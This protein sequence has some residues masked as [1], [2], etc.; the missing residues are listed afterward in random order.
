MA[1]V[2]KTVST[3]IKERAIDIK[4]ISLVEPSKSE[5]GIIPEP[6]LRWEPLRLNSVLLWLC[7]FVLFFCLLTGPLFPRKLGRVWVGELFSIAHDCPHIGRFDVL[8]YI[9]SQ[10]A[11]ASPTMSCGS[12]ARDTLSEAWADPSC[13]AFLSPKDTPL[14]FI[15][16]LSALPSSNPALLPKQS[17]PSTLTYYL[18]CLSSPS[19]ILVPAH[20]FNLI[21][22]SFSRT[23]K[24][25]FPVMC[26]CQPMPPK[27]IALFREIWGQ[28]AM[29]LRSHTFIEISTKLCPGWRQPYLI[30]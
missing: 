15:T 16:S 7:S 24:W 12:K 13:P 20:K 2:R 26:G 6:E 17:C 28:N 5:L 22:L 29:P 27:E 4:L 9:D 18:Y 10:R 3:L 30:F 14:T 21:T 1:I 25:L 11:V 23:H 19:C 8:Y